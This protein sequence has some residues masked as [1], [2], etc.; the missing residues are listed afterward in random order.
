VSNIDASERNRAT[1]SRRQVLRGAAAIAGAAIGSGV[2]RGFPT[3]WAQ[4]IKDVTLIHIGGPWAVIKQIGDQAK[5]DLGFT[6]DMQAIDP[7]SQLQRALTQPKSFDIH[8][9]DNSTIKYIEHAG[10]LKPIAVKDY[11]LWD[12]TLSMFTIGTFPSGKPIPDQ[13]LSPMMTGFWDGPDAKKF[14]GKPSDWLTMVPTVFN[15]DTLG[16]RPDL[17]GGKDAV[18]SWTDLLDPKYDGK[19]AL[20]DIAVV[21][22]M[23]VAMALEARGDMKYGNKGNM[24]RAE[25]DK[26]FEIVTA[27]K[28]SGHFRAFWTNFDQSVNLMASGEVVVQ[29]MWS[30]AVTAV[31][32]RGIPC[33]YAPLKEGY[34]GWTAGITPMAH[35][36]GLK[37]DC[38]MEYINWYNSGW[39]GGFIAKQGYY[40]PVPETAKKFLTQA[41]WDYWYEGKPA[42]VDITDPY[43]T[44]EDKKGEV[45]DGGSLWER[46]E[47]ISVW[48]T[49]M[50]EDRY[51]TRQWIAFIAG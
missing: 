37:L 4:N 2:V 12:K 16:V 41:D 11:K 30:P 28:K 18:T 35:L 26:T 27:I 32:A 33:Y 6:V 1:V 22:T 7:A 40:S 46:E 38:A 24:T 42:A 29:S 47:R 45:R 49:V 3:I 13:G 8:Q 50:D 21:G 25:I 19:A 23:D 17:V 14:A 31:K 36:S 44:L 15:A 51:M 5:T 34:R 20:N 43:G 39:Q 10:V 9:S 48:N